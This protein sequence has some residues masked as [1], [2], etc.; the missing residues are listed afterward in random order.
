MNKEKQNRVAT[1]QYNLKVYKNHLKLAEQLV[2]RFKDGAWV[3]C[4][5]D[6]NSSGNLEHHE[7]LMRKRVCDTIREKI[8]AAQTELDK[9]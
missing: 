1:L 7:N 9:M 3:G 6:L 5:H 4:W 8:K 2:S